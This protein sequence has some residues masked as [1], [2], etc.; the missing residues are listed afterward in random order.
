M[1]DVNIKIGTQGDISGLQKI[2]SG[3]QD[4]LNKV[5]LTYQQFQTPVTA[6]ADKAGAKKDLDALNQ[7]A[8][9][10]E[11]KI[12][13]TRLDILQGVE[14]P[15]GSPRHLEKLKQDL[16][17]TGLQRKIAQ[18]DMQQAPRGATPAQ[19]LAGGAAFLGRGALKYG[20]IAAGMMGAFSLFSNISERMGDAEEMNRR[21]AMSMSVMRGQT[22]L[23]YKD[24]E[25]FY[26]IDEALR[27]LGDTAF[28]TSK[29]MIPLNDVMRELS[30]TVARPIKIGEGYI[31]SVYDPSYLWGE[32]IQTAN[33]GKSLEVEPSVITEF[34]LQGL[35]QGSFKE[36]TGLGTDFISKLMLNPNMR[37]RATE[38]VQAMGTVLTGSAQGVQGP[39][40]YG[41]YNLIQTLNE[42]DFETYRGSRGAQALLRMD[43]AFQGGGS[44]NL[45]YFQA[46]A[47][48]PSFQESNRLRT[49]EYNALQKRESVDFGTGRFDQYISDIFQE[50]GAFGTAGQVEEQLRKLGFGKAA[51]YVSERY[52]DPTKMNIERLFEQYRSAYA[53]KDEGSRMLMTAQ[54]AR[55]LG[56]SFTDIGVLDEA[57]RD[58]EFMRRAGKAGLDLS[59]VAE[60]RR[61]W[62]ES[63][64]DVPSMDE[65]IKK[66]TT[67]EESFQSI[68]KNL[69]RIA[70]EL[71][72]V[73]ANDIGPALVSASQSIADLV[74]FFTGNDEKPEISP[75][76]VSD[77]LNDPVSAFG[78]DLSNM[79]QRGMDDIRNPSQIFYP[80]LHPIEY[81]K[82]LQRA[83]ANDI[84]ALGN[85]IDRLADKINSKPTNITFTGPPGA[86]VIE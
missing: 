69:K 41:I 7:K 20:G 34:M 43:Q 72:P 42:L 60:S 80:I 26:E 25:S 53:A 35:R 67:T 64:K 22:R 3:V 79:Y 61:Q 32:Y 47:L 36:G 49:A 44:E 14:G 63:G 15:A 19:R 48:S 17:V 11:R 40:A 21:F 10:I 83:G 27:R 75:V 12:A 81:G 57:L 84:E 4:L 5:K 39:R 28:M 23:D 58:K 45:Q 51:E 13:Q 71:L 50:V 37:H 46:M 52:E 1:T 70:D 6:L 9:N 85:L 2:D 76:T 82:D 54:M 29:D 30:A 24:V 31:N 68:A 62:I 86:Q 77:Y 74:R 16:E 66:K 59:E 56:V 38:A 55:D 8:S 18:I 33:I 73:F 65:Y 78:R